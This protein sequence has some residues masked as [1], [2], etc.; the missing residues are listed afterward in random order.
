M[1][2][3]LIPSVNIAAGY[4]T[5]LRRGRRAAQRDRPGVVATMRLLGQ[6][7]SMAMATLVFA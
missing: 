2:P 7:A 5:D 6:M 3:F 1:G 4:S